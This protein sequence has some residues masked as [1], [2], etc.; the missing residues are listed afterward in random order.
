[1]RLR[2]DVDKPSS[3]EVFDLK[4]TENFQIRCHNEECLKYVYS[5]NKEEIQ[6]L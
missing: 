5:T 6:A 1:M 4:S 3:Y 2:K